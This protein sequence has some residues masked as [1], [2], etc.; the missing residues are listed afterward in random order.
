VSPVERCYLIAKIY[1]LACAHGPVWKGLCKKSKEL[2]C[3]LALNNI[4]QHV[5]WAFTILFKVR[6]AQLLHHR[7][8]ILIPL[9]L[10]LHAAINRVRFVFSRMSLSKHA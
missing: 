4:A 6:S 9:K 7:P 10:R 2:T 3:Y 1:C 5:H 8:S